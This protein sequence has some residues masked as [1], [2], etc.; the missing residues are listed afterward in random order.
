[1]TKMKWIHQNQLSLSDH[2]LVIRQLANKCHQVDMQ[3]CKCV[4]GVILEFL[5]QEPIFLFKEDP[6][7]LFFSQNIYCPHFRT[8][9]ME[10]IDLKK[11][12]RLTLKYIIRPCAVKLFF[13]WHGRTILRWLWILYN[14]TRWDWVSQSVSSNAR[15]FFAK[16]LGMFSSIFFWGISSI[17]ET[18]WN[19]IVE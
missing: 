4:T 9:W 18:S 13:P 6:N 7:S 16:I 19:Q 5:W 11:D 15:F 17:S 8:F 2:W 12:K 10:E 1:M 3:R 14:K